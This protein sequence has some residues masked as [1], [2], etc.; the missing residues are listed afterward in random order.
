MTDRPQKKVFDIVRPG[1]TMASPSSRPILTSQKPPV[2]DSQVAPKGED[3]VE[4]SVRSGNNTGKRQM[5]PGR[6][7]INLSADDNTEL[8]HDVDTPTAPTVPAAVLRRKKI[9]APINPIEVD[10]EDEPATVNVVTKP[11]SIPTEPTTAPPMAA[12][13]TPDSPVPDVPADDEESDVFEGIDMSDIEPVKATP[14]VP[15]PATTTEATPQLVRSTPTKVNIISREEQEAEDQLLQVDESERASEDADD[16]AP[17]QSADRDA[18]EPDYN[19][20]IAAKHSTSRED[21]MSGADMAMPTH[22]DEEERRPVV[23][24][25]KRGKLRWWQWLLVIF[26]ILL[27]AAATVN[28]LIDAEIL[29]TNLN[30]PH[31]NLL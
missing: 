5:M 27:L 25:H 9:I 10:A 17:A 8:S 15:A 28:F 20:P 22:D 14:E 1:K 31:T 11:A 29:N 18:D 6:T 4:V 24:H 30:I 3:N 7:T 12:S 23:S 21:I 13:V 2:V 19:A 26:F 16:E